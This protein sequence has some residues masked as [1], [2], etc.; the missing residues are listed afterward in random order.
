MY[1]LIIFATACGLVILL[2]YEIRYRGMVEE[3]DKIKHN[4]RKT[5]EEI[6]K[7]HE[8]MKLK[9]N[10]YEEHNPSIY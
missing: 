4:A 5:N 2:G 3:M 1:T 9:K 6:V 8:Q 7:L 10:I